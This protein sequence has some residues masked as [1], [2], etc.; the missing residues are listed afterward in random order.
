MR[1]KTQYRRSSLGECLL[2]VLGA[3]VMVVVFLAAV[4]AVG[5]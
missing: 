4:A 3:L 5:R 2:A 1:D